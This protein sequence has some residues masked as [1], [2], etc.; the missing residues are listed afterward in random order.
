MQEFL[1]LFDGRIQS[2]AMAHALLSRSH[3]QGVSLADLVHSE[4]APCVKEGSSSVEGPEVLI[5]AEATQAIGIVLHELV[6]NASKYGALSTPNGR[7]SVRWDWLK[8]GETAELL[9][10]VWTEA[11]GPVVAL[12]YR[13]GY[14]TGV[15]RDLIPYELGGEVE[16]LFDPGGLRCTVD[17]PSKW[18]R[19]TPAPF[20]PMT[21]DQ[22]PVEESPI[23][24]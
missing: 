10:L 9:R 23:A 7:I 3:W 24:T 20:R 12:P 19:G 18:I 4:L 6:T 17:L 11:G 5:S 13:H 1:S 15:I 14:G 16:L 21:S 2:M 22:A 8:N